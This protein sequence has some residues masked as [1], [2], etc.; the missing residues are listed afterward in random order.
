M[1]KYLILL[2]LI[3]AIKTEL[4]A[5]GK[6][7]GNVINKNQ[8]IEFASVTIASKKDSTKVLLYEATDSLGKFSFKNLS[9]GEYVVKISLVGFQPITRK[10]VLSQEKTEYTFINQTLANDESDLIKVVVT[11]QKRMIEKTDEGFI[12]NT[13]NNISQIGGTA[14]DLLKATPTVTVDND[15]VITLRGKSP[16]ILINGRNSG[17]SNTDQI[18]ATSVE[19]I[20]IINNASSKYDANAE[21]GIINIRLKKNKQ[22][23]TNGA[24]ALGTGFGSKARANTSI[25]LN[26]K[27]GK[28]NWGL[29]YDNRFA[30]RTRAVESNRTNYNLFDIYSVNQNRNDKRIEGLQ[31]LKFNADYAANEFNSFSLEAIGVIES[32]DNNEDLISK[33]I[34]VLL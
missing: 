1:N 13:A 19:S 27:K 33:I 17:L 21:S 9:L 31:N 8:A 12:V 10:I 29:G 16:L 34:S 3:I 30:G 23:G 2:F 18:A 26:N 32:Q 4:L 25:I 11:A 15:G 14:T 22:S 6:I 5:Q 24:I 28:F 20:E 7:S